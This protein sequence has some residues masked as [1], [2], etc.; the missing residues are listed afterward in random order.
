[1]LTFFI[2][3]NLLPVRHWPTVYMISPVCTQV[4]FYKTEIV[5][6]RKYVCVYG[7]KENIFIRNNT[8]WT[9]ENSFLNFKYWNNFHGVLDFVGHSQTHFV[10]ASMT[11]NMC[12]FC[13]CFLM[14]LNDQNDKRTVEFFSFPTGC[15]KFANHTF[16]N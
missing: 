11:E 14:Y 7:V 2:R 10:K 9:H 4:N 6:R 15:N 8:G 1:M 16:V 3:S 13:S 5:T 12:N